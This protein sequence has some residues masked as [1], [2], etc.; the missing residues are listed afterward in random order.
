[1]D[2]NKGLEEKCTQNTESG[3]HIQMHLLV[4]EEKQKW[5]QYIKRFKYHLE[6]VGMFQVRKSSSRVD[7]RRHRHK[8]EHRKRK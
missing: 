7:F 6:S 4:L 5:E 8:K 1:M 3:A 2:K